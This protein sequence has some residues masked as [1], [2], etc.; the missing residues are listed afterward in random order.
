MQPVSRSRRNI[1]NLVITCSI[2]AVGYLLWDKNQYLMYT[3]S[4]ESK[5]KDLN[6]TL[7]A[8][9]L[10]C[11]PRYMVQG[12]NENVGIV[13]QQ[14]LEAQ[15][16]ELQ[17]HLALIVA[18][19]ESCI[20]N[21]ELSKE[22]VAEKQALELQIIKLNK[23]LE[24]VMVDYSSRVKII[25]LALVDYDRQ[26]DDL[27]LLSREV[28]STIQQKLDNFKQS[29]NSLDPNNRKTTLDALSA[30]MKEL[31]ILD[32]PRFTPAFS[33]HQVTMVQT[34]PDKDDSNNDHK[35]DNK[36]D[37]KENNKDSREDDQDLTKDTKDTIDSPRL[38]I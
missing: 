22:H 15:I 36:A 14:K 18:D 19:C 1:S 34:A 35:V 2:A 25:D 12:S 8:A 16:K 30:R 20:K 17:Q 33:A 28:I 37:D 23:Q 21:I 26:Y 11:E 27:L 13:N 32:M 9:L 10:H 38:T 31:A 3:Q 5:I 7:D 4:L 6:N 24:V 29:L